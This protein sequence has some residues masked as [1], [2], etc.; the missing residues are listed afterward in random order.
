MIKDVVTWVQSNTTKPWLI[1]GKGPSAT[2]IETIDHAQY[3]ILSLNHACL[4]TP[5]TLAHFV[6]LEALFDCHAWLQTCHNTAPTCLVVP[7]YPHRKH[8]AQ[9][10][11]LAN[12]IELRRDPETLVP[13]FYAE[14]SRLLSYNGSTAI[15][16]PAAPAL[17]KV[18]LRYFSATAAFHIL[19]LA[20]IRTIHSL[21]IDGGTKY[22]TMFAD[23]KPLQN[24]RTSFNVQMPVLEKCVARYKIDWQKL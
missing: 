7:W 20:G 15:K 17:A 6:D 21:G 8:K 22:A 9:Q 23:I 1:L 16:R 2:K 11:T 19:A 18:Q 14:N 12:W 10:Q 3:H 5:P 13:R 24:G 4:F